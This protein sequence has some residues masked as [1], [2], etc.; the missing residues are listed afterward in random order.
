MVCV[1]LWAH[2]AAAA[3]GGARTTEVLVAPDPGEL[4]AHWNA[5]LREDHPMAL[6]FKEASYELLE[7]ED[8]EP[9][10][11]C[12]YDGKGNE[13]AR[14]NFPEVPVSSDGRAWVVC[15]W[16]RGRYRLHIDSL[17]VTTDKVPEGDGNSE[18]FEVFILGTQLSKSASK[19]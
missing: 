9:G 5:M 17:F 2:T 3:D 1:F 11:D 10:L 19:T 8:G 16:Q 6:R 7:S 18:V 4:V 14:R 12:W 13:F 15:R